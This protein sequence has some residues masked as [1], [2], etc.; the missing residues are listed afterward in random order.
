[1]L[2]LRYLCGISALSLHYPCD[3]S[4]TMG[5]TIPPDWALNLTDDLSEYLIG[6]FKDLI[7]ADRN[8][9]SDESQVVPP[10]SLSIGLVEECEHAAQVLAA[11]FLN[12][13]APAIL[14][15]YYTSLF[16]ATHSLQ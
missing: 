14:I 1:M 8:D 12:Q 5:T 4:A 11:A 7:A 16:R 2:S 10:T 3:I 9:R 15:C 13:G 6:V